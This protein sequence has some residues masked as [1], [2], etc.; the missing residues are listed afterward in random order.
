MV[1]PT[2]G[3]VLTAQHRMCTTVGG[4]LSETI[5]TVSLRTE[6]MLSMFQLR[7]KNVPRPDRTDVVPGRNSTETVPV[8][9][10]T[11]IIYCKLD[12]CNSLYYKLLKSQLSHLQQI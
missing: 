10:L 1:C 7:N 3:T 12:Y 11:S 2:A 4:A 9:S 5:A 8:R 6:K